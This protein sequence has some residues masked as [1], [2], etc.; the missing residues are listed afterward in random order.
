MGHARDL[1]LKQ[2]NKFGDFRPLSF[3]SVHKSR[4]IDAHRRS[5]H[6]DLK[7]INIGSSPEVPWTALMLQRAVGVCLG[8]AGRRAVGC[9][10]VAI[11]IDLWGLWARYPICREPR[12]YVDLKKNC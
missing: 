4:Q 9:Q 7:K 10:K 8:G 2:A 5:R 11:D 6:S 1:L 3:H 12:G